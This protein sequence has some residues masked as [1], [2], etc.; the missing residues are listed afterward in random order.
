MTTMEVIQT[1]ANRNNDNVS[2]NG[3]E[4]ALIEQAGAGIVADPATGMSTFRAKTTWQ[5]R[6]R[7]RTDIESYDL[8]GVRIPRHH[9]IVSDEPLE[10]LG[11]NEA[12]NP[13]DLLLAALNAC[14]TVGFVVGA[15]MAG[16]RID[17]LEIESECPLDL[18]GAFGL[19]PNVPPGAAKIKYTVR[20]KG[21]GTRE[22]FEEVHKAMM[23]TSPNRYHISMPIPLESTLVVV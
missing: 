15:T 10:L 4:P 11:T 9:R 16:I 7:S 23:A 17:A 2:L 18:R 14:M 8:G 19:D 6:F 3:L 13:Q 21:S 20:V 1:A 5:G 12:P 22:Q